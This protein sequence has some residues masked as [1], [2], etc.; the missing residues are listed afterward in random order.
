[1]ILIFA[2]VAG[3]RGHK[4][5]DHTKSKPTPAQRSPQT[6][7]VVPKM[8]HGIKSPHSTGAS[9]H[10]ETVGLT[11]TSVPPRLLDEPPSVKFCKLI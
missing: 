11:S 7:A 5:K 10:S 8:S 1:M 9:Q 2:A 3:R 6:S 4:A